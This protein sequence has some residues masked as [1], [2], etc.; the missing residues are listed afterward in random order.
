[1]ALSKYEVSARYG[2][3]LF[4]LAE[5]HQQTVAINDELIALRQLLCDNPR[6][7]MMLADKNVAFEQKQQLLM[8][9]QQPFTVF[10]QNL[11]QMV[12][13]YGHITN[14][15]DIIA[16]YQTRFDKSRGRIHATVI[17]AVPMSKTQEQAMQEA[18][19]QRFNAQ[20]II[21]TSKIDANIVGGAITKVKDIIIDGSLTTRIA[22]LKKY[23]LQSLN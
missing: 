20:E 15:L 14:L 2:R 7:I 10:V 4:D 19:K 12:Y 3:A 13:D 23:L 9:L 8:T 17:T 16:D 22:N 18:L 6:A 5:E 1:M 11:L 21:L